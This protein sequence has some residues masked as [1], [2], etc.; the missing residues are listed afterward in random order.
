MVNVKT[1]IGSIGNLFYAP[2]SGKQAGWGFLLGIITW[3]F[4][5]LTYSLL[6]LFVFTFMD[7]LTGLLKAAKL[8]EI[9]SSKMSKTAYKLFG[10]IIFV[11]LMAVVFHR[12][13]P[14]IPGLEPG[15]RLIPGAMITM[16][17]VIP[18]FII[19]ILSIREIISNVEN[20]SIAEII[21]KKVAD[22]FLGILH[23]VDKKI[24][25][26]ITERGVSN[27]TD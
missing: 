7:F 12:F 18:H 3:I 4:G 1:L 14:Q 22:L 10:Y 15:S 13:L 20:L 21:P 26:N 24:E 23:S 25:K 8:G 16:F 19:A 27:E 2:T 9:A 11:A 5:D 6:I 17:K